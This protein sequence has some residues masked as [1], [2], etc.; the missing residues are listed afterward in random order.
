ML[1]CSFWFAC[2]RSLS[3]RLLRI[4][5]LADL[6]RRFV[7]M[8][9]IAAA[10]MMRWGFIERRALQRPRQEAGSDRRR[11]CRVGGRDGRRIRKTS[12]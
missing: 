3:R 11:G 12:I 6:G 7:L 1:W 5:D 10:I 2:D 8:I 9:V 4:A